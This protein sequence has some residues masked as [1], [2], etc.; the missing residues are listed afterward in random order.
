MQLFEHVKGQRAAL[1]GLLVEESD[2]GDFVFVLL[3]VIGKALNHGLGRAFCLLAE[4]AEGDLVE[5]DVVDELLALA[6]GVFD[7]VAQ[8]R[9]IK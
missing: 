6:T 3:D 8:F 2:R 4:A 7:L 5:V 9:T 1:V